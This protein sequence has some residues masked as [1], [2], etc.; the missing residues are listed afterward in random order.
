MNI[1]KYLLP[2]GAVLL[3]G[4]SLP[5]ADL[6]AHYRATSIAGAE[7]P[8]NYGLRLDGFYDG[9][10]KSVVTFG[11]DN[12]FLDEFNDNTIRLS[13]TITVVKAT[14]S[15]DG[16]NSKGNGANQVSYDAHLSGENGMHSAI[17]EYVGTKYFLEVTMKQVTDPDS[18]AIIENFN[19]SWKYYTIMS[20]GLEME[21]VIDSGDHARLWSF[22]LDGSKP[23]QVG[24]GANGK[25]NNFGAAGW[26]SFEHVIGEMIFGNTFDGHFRSSD[27]LMDLS[28]VTDVGDN[29]P[30]TNLPKG[31]E[32]RGN[33]PN[34]FNPSTTIEYALPKRMHVTIDIYNTLGQLVRQ[35]VNSEKP[36]GEHLVEWD[37]TDNS[38]ANVST[39]IYFYRVQGDSFAQSRKMVLLK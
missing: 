31:F 3:L 27:F 29:D 37:G 32:L 14:C 16:D 22:P 38:G 17:D 35:L 15:G 20:D 7:A 9:K 5:A 11:Y 30:V 6:I 26:L 8:P 4:G 28:Q 39:G 10:A 13:G 33:Y 18:I 1:S 19:P 23:F 24:D 21:N 34:P 25:N 36:A 12:V 2:L